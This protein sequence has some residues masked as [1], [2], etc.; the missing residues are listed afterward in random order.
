MWIEK[1]KQLAIACIKWADSILGGGTIEE[2]SDAR[3]TLERAVN[4]CGY[5]AVTLAAGWNVTASLM[6]EIMLIANGGR[7]TGSAFNPSII[8]DVPIYGEPG[9]WVN[10]LRKTYKLGKKE[11]GP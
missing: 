3:L 2:H 4:D 8:R 11:N 7:L 10:K 6:V 9:H 5:D 1:E